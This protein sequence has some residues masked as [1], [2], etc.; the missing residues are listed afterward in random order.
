MT[1]R[2]FVFLLIMLSSAVTLAQPV[3]PSKLISVRDAAEEFIHSVPP[4]ATIESWIKENGPVYGNYC[5]V[6]QG[7]A[8]FE[9]LCL[10]RLDCVC[11]ALDFSTSLK[12]HLAPEAALLENI[13]GKGALTADRRPEYQ[14]FMK[15]I[16]LKLLA[17]QIEGVNINESVKAAVALYPKN[18]KTASA[19]LDKLI[20]ENAIIRMKIEQINVERIKFEEARFEADQPSEV[21]TKTHSVTTQPFNII[22]GLFSLN[23]EQLLGKQFTFRGGVN[24]FGAGL[25]TDTYL[26]YGQKDFSVFMSLGLK[27]FVW[28]QAL[29]AGVYVEPYFDVG[30]ENVAIP[31]NSTQNVRDIAM[32]PSLLVGAEKVFPFGLHIEA[33]VGGGYHCGILLSD[34]PTGT[35]T[36]FLVPKFRASVG[37]AW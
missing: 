13:L 23:Y 22:A 3:S 17:A 34:N 10:G 21:S 8:S 9:A 26:G 12:R 25:I 5:G 37:F 6:K 15:S 24:F 18:P 1:T 11:K 28:G 7:D 29:K 20:D 36:F 19:D 35:A 2:Q 27:S 30:Y 31:T 16:S 33:G 14:S 32:V 4:Y